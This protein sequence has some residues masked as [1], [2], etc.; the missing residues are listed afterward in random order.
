M[1]ARVRST[2]S[3]LRCGNTFPSTGTA[4]NLF[5]SPSVA[6]TFSSWAK[7]SVRSP[8]ARYPM[9]T[10]T[11][12]LVALASEKASAWI[13]P[14]VYKRCE[15][16]NPLLGTYDQR[17]HRLGGKPFVGV[18]IEIPH[19]RRPASTSPVPVSCA[20][21]RPSRSEFTHNREFI[22]VSRE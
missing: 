1:Y 14:G 10:R 15:Q 18:R 5:G 20:V 6:T 3:N 19:Q 21:L 7:A 12:R 8:A 11:P 2:T 9:V 13:P 22:G 17:N 4:V 16:S